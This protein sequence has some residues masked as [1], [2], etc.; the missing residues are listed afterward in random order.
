MSIV[1]LKI[2]SYN[3]KGI[4]I[5]VWNR[6]DNHVRVKQKEH[7]QT[8][9]FYVL[10]SKKVFI[11]LSVK[12]LFSKLLGELDFVTHKEITFDD[13]FRLNSSSNGDKCYNPFK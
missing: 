5:E 10:K 6:F 12:G 3:D 13:Y 7:E 2:D 9:I 11:F 8:N 1:Q 4:I